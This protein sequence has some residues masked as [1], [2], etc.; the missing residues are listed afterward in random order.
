MNLKLSITDLLLCGASII[1]MLTIVLLIRRMNSKNYV[2]VTTLSLYFAMI[3]GTCICILF[4]H[5]KQ[6]NT[7]TVLVPIIFAFVLSA[8][9][10]F[11]YLSL[12]HLILKTNLFKLKNLIHFAPILLMVTLMLVFN[13]VF[14]NNEKNFISVFETQSLMYSHNNSNYIVGVFR[15]LHPTVYL[16]LGGNLIYSLYRT[17]TITPGTKSIRWFI[18][19]IYFQKIILMFWFLVGVVGFKYNF[20]L[21]SQ[22]AITA[23]SIAAFFTSTYVLLSP[24]L[25][26]QITKIKIDQ[27]KRKD[28]S[29]DLPNLIEQLNSL[30]KTNE[31]YSKP[32]YNFINLSS[33][34]GISANNIREIITACGFKNYS[35]FMNSFRMDHAENLIQNGYLNT[36]SLESLSRVS[37]FQSE[38]TFYRVFKKI[39]N[40]T[41][42]EYSYALKPA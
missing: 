13:P 32:K 4:L 10:V 2:F 17:T 7:N 35:A 29:S 33:D 23:Y 21:F 40:C 14:S 8:H 42:I 37:G 11:H 24:D 1:L 9:N 38:A 31:L 15:L 3:I 19:F 26:I 28:L 16:I 39:H 12:Q 34:S 18:Y 30:I 20:E 36:Y 6:A 22:I 5:L 25:S 41:P 27:K